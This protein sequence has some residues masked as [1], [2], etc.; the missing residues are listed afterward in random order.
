MVFYNAGTFRKS[1][2][3]GA[4]VFDLGYSFANSGTLDVQAGKVWF[5]GPYSESAAAGIKVL[6]G[7]P[8][9]VTQYS[10]IAFD[11]PPVFAGRFE[12]TMS[13]AYRP[14]A[15][16]SFTVLT[17]PSKTGAFNGTAGLELGGGLSLVPQYS[18]TALNLVA[19]QNTTP[20]LAAVGISAGG[21]LRITWPADYAGWELYS[22]TNIANPVWRRVPLTGGV[23][24][25]LPTTNSA[26]VF[27]LRKP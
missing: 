13:N 19:T 3:A 18:A 6:I 2:G 11:Q 16:T 20:S 14:S 10:Q 21:S 23:T 1:R 4:G 24:V 26:E 22:A 5:R 25:D 17:F 7:G 12:V 9:P 27:R 15:G 8:T